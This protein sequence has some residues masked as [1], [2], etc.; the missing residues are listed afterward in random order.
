MQ[1]DPRELCGQT[2]IFEDK[3]KFKIKDERY[4][5]AAHNTSHNVTCVFNTKKDAP[6]YKTGKKLFY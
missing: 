2:I 4:R 3:S 1:I 6:R 5:I